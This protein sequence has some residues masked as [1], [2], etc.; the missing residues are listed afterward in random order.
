MFYSEIMPLEVEKTKLVEWRGRIT[1]T[2][3]EDL[4]NIE[5]QIG[6]PQAAL[7]RMALDSFLPKISNSGFTLNGIKAGYLN[8]GY[9]GVRG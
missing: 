8:G 2:Q 6:V 7:V 4:I 9:D 5:N 1:E 3:K